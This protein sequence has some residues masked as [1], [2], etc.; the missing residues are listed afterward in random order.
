MATTAIKA[1]LPKN[2]KSLDSKMGMN[3]R[4][5]AQTMQKLQ[6][7]L[8]PGLLK[9]MGGAGG[10]QAIMKAVGDGKGMPGFPGMR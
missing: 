6:A 4:N 10:L 9:Q 1:A 2:A 7:G 3:P 5:M 8:P